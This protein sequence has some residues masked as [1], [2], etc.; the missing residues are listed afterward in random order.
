MGPKLNFRLGGIL[1][2]LRCFLV[3][4]RSFPSQAW[5]HLQEISARYRHL[6]HLYKRSSSNQKMGRLLDI[7]LPKCGLL[8]GRMY[9]NNFRDV[10]NW[11]HHLKVSYR[12]LPI[13][14]CPFMVGKELNLCN[15]ILIYLL[16]RDFHWAS[17]QAMGNGFG[18]A[19]AWLG[20]GQYRFN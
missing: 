19:P 20:P 6:K 7:C 4:F 11:P 17:G 10:A 14:H 15:T 8:P 9:T 12:L 3:F 5:A 1:V 13:D 16:R 18:L 2:V